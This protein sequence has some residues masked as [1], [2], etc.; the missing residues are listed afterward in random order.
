M[1]PE[2]IYYRIG[3]VSRLTGISEHT[4]RYWEKE[5]PGLKPL[6]SSRG[7]DKPPGPRLYRAA[8]LETI[9]KIRELLHERGLRVAAARLALRRQPGKE[10][11][12]RSGAPV[13]RRLMRRLETV[14]KLLR[15]I[16]ESR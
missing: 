11:A 5:F 8:D 9:E 12:G 16:E 4:L 1:S 2:R 15:E 14:E 10:A 3:E 13:S 7:R 6:R